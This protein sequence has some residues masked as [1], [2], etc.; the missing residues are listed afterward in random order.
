[1]NHTTSKATVVAAMIWMADSEAGAADYKKNPY[2][3]VYEDAIEA[4]A[5]TLLR[6][7]G[8]NPRS[9]AATEAGQGTKPGKAAKGQAVRKPDDGDLRMPTKEELLAEDW[10]R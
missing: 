2:T 7:Y 4:Q 9:L 3:L 6:R 5:W 8:V 10:T 1:M